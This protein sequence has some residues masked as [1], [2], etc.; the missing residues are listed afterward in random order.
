MGDAY[1]I[2]RDCGEYKPLTDYYPHSEMKDG[3]LN[4]YKVCVKNRVCKHRAV[5]ID[6]LREYDLERA[7]KGRVKELR[8]KFPNKYKVMG[9]VAT[10]LS[11]GKI[12]RPSTCSSCGKICKPQAHHWSYEEEHWLDVVWLCTRCHADEH[13]RLREEGRDPDINII[14]CGNDDS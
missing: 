7:R 4:K 5:N 2:C 9:A 12:S 10:A 14:G 11:S 8:R 1:K 6:A 13:V 3:H